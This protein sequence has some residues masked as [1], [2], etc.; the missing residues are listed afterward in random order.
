M[1]TPARSVTPGDILV[2][3]VIYKTYWALVM[4]QGIGC[5]GSSFVK[6]EN[7]LPDL[8]HN[9]LSEQVLTKLNRIPIVYTDYCIEYAIGLVHDTRRLSS[10]CLWTRNPMQQSHLLHKK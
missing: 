1:R 4:L 10:R 6:R 8:H 7:N 3:D 9:V 5:N 2:G